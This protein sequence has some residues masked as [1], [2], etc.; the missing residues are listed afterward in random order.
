MPNTLSEGR[1]KFLQKINPELHKAFQ[2]LDE[3][4]R[5]F[6]V[7]N[8]SCKNAEKEHQKM[9]ENI[10]NANQ[11][12]LVKNMGLNIQG[13][14]AILLSRLERIL[15]E[16]EKLMNKLDNI[17]FEK[18]YQKYRD[19]VSGTIV[20]QNVCEVTIGGIVERSELAP[21]PKA[22]SYPQNEQVTF[23]EAGNMFKKQQKPQLSALELLDRVM[24]EICP[25]NLALYPYG[26]K[27]GAN[28][29]VEKDQKPV[30]TPEQRKAIKNLP[31]D[32][33][34]ENPYTKEMMRKN[35]KN[36]F[37]EE[38]PKQPQTILSR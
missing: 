11:R 13:Q 5:V 1:M 28:A 17:D 34:V 26:N 21:K 7:N 38:A 8:T 33:K 30:I 31:K 35:I 4:T 12:E 10:I 29:S 25:S 18:R 15:A 22:F 19:N 32:P 24:K 16:R 27:K 36:L 23:G 9:S 3:K 20:K 6:D 2:T 37:G 14:K